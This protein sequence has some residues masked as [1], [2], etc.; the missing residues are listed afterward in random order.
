ME[1]AAS[2][3]SIGQLQE[4]LKWGEPAFVTPSGAGTTIRINAHKKSSDTAGLY[5][6]CQTNLV[7]RWRDLYG[8][9]LEFEGNRAILF[10]I[11]KPM[12]KAAIR[13]CIAMALTYH[14]RI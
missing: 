4:T 3:S 13:H 8:E 9:E 2:D 1:V 10:D 12:P 11:S 14:R 5:V 6:P 7:D